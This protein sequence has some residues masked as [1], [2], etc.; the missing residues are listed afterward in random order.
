MADFQQA[1]LREALAATLGKTAEYWQYDRENRTPMNFVLDAAAA[2]MSSPFSVVWVDGGHPEIFCLRG[3]SPS[4]VVYSTRY[5]SVSAFVRHLFLGVY[6]DETLVET[7]ER[8]ALKVIA[9][10]ALRHGD[11]D[12]AVLA[13]VKSITG[14]GIWT[15]D[16]DQIMALEH[17]PIGEAYMA[18]W[19][20]GLLHELGHFDQADGE[21]LPETH[22]F[23][24]QGILAAIADELERFRA[25]PDWVKSEALERAKEP[26]S[27]SVLAIEHLR[28][29]GLADIFAASVLFKATFDIMQMSGN[30]QFQVLR[31]VQELIISY[32]IIAV[33]DRCRRMASIASTTTVAP[34]A[35]YEVGFHPVAMGVRGRMQRQ[36]LDLAV[37]N[38]MYTDA[39]PEQAR[40]VVGAINEISLGLADGVGKV[41]TGISR[42]MQFSLFP[43]KRENDWALLESF[44][45]GLSKSV[46]SELASAEA[47]RF[48]AM[49]DSLGVDGK[50]LKALKG[51]LQAPLAPLQ[52]DPT[53]DLVYFVPW[54]EG[55]NGTARPFGL[56]TKH[57]HLVFVF[58]D[59]H[60]VYPSFFEIS[61]ETL[62]PG[63]TLKRAV[64]CVPRPERL[65][66]ELA[67]NMNRGQAFQ[68][69]LEGTEEFLRY[70]EE[71]RTDTIWED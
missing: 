16:E 7:A 40:D 9:E 64:V 15:S 70:L 54:V 21:K 35:A 46:G 8:T 19:F 48:C 63:F 24:D 4:Q 33:I 66:P 41:D 26:R 67:A 22:P 1:A 49:A 30:K 69:V 39:S 25:F 36:Y 14:K 32:N 31:F 61:A 59:A 53:G 68:I 10:M 57:G 62:K 23:S 47:R 29:E 18:T 5:L 27:T 11:P 3:F 56:D 17:E 13:F 52:P 20:F 28:A 65:G 44:R 60:G 42:A 37:T 6:Q 50:L 38:Y 12:F 71:L 43:E 55:P 34:E 58:V 45:L 51:I 2:Q